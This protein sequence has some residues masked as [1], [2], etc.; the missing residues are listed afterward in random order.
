VGCFTC[1]AVKKAIICRTAS[2]TVWGIIAGS[3]TLTHGRCSIST[4]VGGYSIRPFNRRNRIQ[5]TKGN[6]YAEITSY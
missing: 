6:C 4:V 3:G 2:G 5:M 1:V